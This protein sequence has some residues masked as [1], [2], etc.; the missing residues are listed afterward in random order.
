MVQ[1]DGLY[2]R[3]SQLKSGLA[4]WMIIMGRQTSKSRRV[5]NKRTDYIYATNT[6]MIS[7]L[8]EKS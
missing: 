2:S 1:S 4:W 5:T 8:V 3:A 7:D 6:H